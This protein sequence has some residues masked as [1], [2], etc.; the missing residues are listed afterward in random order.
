MHYHAYS[1]ICNYWSYYIY[2]LNY[3]VSFFIYWLFFRYSKR[4]ASLN[5]QA[6]LPLVK[7][8]LKLLLRNMVVLAMIVY[9]RIDYN[10]NNSF[11]YSFISW[12][13]VLLWILE[14]IEI[15]IDILWTTWWLNKMMN[16]LS[17]IDCC[18]YDWLLQYCCIF[19]IFLILN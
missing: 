7:Y 4:K 1:H 3:Y 18:L 8:P 13:D 11:I 14:F 10:Y 5:N 17:R 12:F 15:P 9:F 2:I 6:Y 16:W 19:L